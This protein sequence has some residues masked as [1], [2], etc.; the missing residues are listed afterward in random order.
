MIT[1]C[2]TGGQAFKDR[3]LLFFTMDNLHVKCRELWHGNCPTGT[4]K[5]ADEWAIE[6][7]I[8]VR[9]FPAAWNVYGKGAGFVRNR[10]MAEARPGL[11]VAFQ[12]ANGT[13]N[14][15]A[16]ANTRGIKVIIIGEWL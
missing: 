8:A 10:V 15:V 16:E 13:R 2:V 9:R 12:G 5:F 4:D 7:G 1:V 11:V 14:M 6:R 3:D